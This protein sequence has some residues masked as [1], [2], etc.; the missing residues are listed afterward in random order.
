MW[1]DS[2][3]LICADFEWCTCVLGLPPGVSNDPVSGCGD[4]QL[5]ALWGNTSHCRSGGRKRRVSNS[6]KKEGC[7]L[8]DSLYGQLIFDRSAKTFN[9]EKNSFLDKSFW[10]NWISHFMIEYTCKK[11][12]EVGPLP[13]TIYKN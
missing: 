12:N 13:Y 1:E 3:M 8:T 10:E 5:S 4:R 2:V 11:K 7:T 6:I 9:G